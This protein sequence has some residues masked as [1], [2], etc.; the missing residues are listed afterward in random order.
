MENK[1]VFQQLKVKI[2]LQRLKI[3]KKNFLSDVQTFTISI[4]RKKLNKTFLF[5]KII[6]TLDE[7]NEPGTLATAMRTIVTLGLEGEHMCYIIA[8]VENYY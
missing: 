6:T 4:E 5:Q 2:I 8:R 1:L 3:E 7:A